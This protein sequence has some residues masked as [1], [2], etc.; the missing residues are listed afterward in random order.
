MVGSQGF[1]L[2]AFFDGA[3]ALDGLKSIVVLVLFGAVVE[4]VESLIA[5]LDI[6]AWV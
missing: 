3:C 5:R 4:P 6:I 2:L 1:S